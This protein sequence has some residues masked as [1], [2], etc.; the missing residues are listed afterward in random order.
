MCGIFGSKK[1][2]QFEALYDRNKERGTFSHGMLF[3]KKEG[4]IFIRKGQGEHSS[5]KE[6][7][8]GHDSDYSTFLG[9]TQAPTSSSRTFK[10]ITSHPF[11]YGNFIVAHNG[12]LENHIQL[13]KK[14]NLKPSRIK[15]D[16][17]IIPRLLE[18]MYVG[19]DVFA[20]QETCEALSG[21]FA[22]WIYS[23]HTSQTYVVRN[24]CTL[25]TNKN[26]T[27]FSSVETSTATEELP[28][29]KILCFTVEGLTEV[30]QFK[31]DC[32]FFIL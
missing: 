17:Q 2:N 27:I 8:W 28:E 12:V 5:E 20:I 10:P 32:P 23:K 29:G 11:E 16:S 9:H 24:G 4:S 22:C 1:F 14:Y 31:S 13:A 15:V 25:Y 21:I 3:T 7:V 26:K 6:R 19:D 30:G 18:Y